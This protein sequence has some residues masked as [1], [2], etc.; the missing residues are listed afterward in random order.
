MCGQA[1]TATHR[2]HKRLIKNISHCNQPIFRPCVLSVEACFL[3]GVYLGIHNRLVSLTGRE[4]L[5]G[6]CIFQGKHGSKSGLQLQLCYVSVLS[7][8]IRPCSHKPILYRYRYTSTAV[9]TKVGLFC[10]CERLV[11]Y[12]MHGV[13]SP[14]IQ[15]QY[16]CLATCNGVSCVHW[17]GTA[18]Q[19]WLLVQ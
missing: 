12:R 15:V 16:G 18:I 2:A 10:Q 17:V 13:L 11:L 14:A 4:R 3:E 5:L 1:A 9:A 6:R 7:C 19:V 8:K